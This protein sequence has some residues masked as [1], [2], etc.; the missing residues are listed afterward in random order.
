MCATNTKF[1]RDVIHHKDLGEL[2]SKYFKL[3]PKFRNF[4]P[5]LQSYSYTPPNPVPTN[6]WE[7]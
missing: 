5:V 6:L 4:G 7:S 3:S 1:Q 2:K